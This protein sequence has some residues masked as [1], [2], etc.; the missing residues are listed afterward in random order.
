MLDIELM[1]RG[2]VKEPCCETF[3]AVAEEHKATKL[4]G[5]GSRLKL[6]WHKNGG[7]VVWGCGEGNYCVLTQV[8]YC[9]W[10]GKALRGNDQVS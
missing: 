9:P 6:Q 5:R 1:R 10:C 3:A 8:E 7:W 2:G 4:P